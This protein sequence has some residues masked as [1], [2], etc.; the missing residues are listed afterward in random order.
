MVSVSTPADR[1]AAHRDLGAA[2]YSSNEV[3]LK[4]R[5]DNA[6]IGDVTSWAWPCLWS[7]G[8]HA[9]VCGWAVQAA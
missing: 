2:S 3:D 1:E 6:S 5:D 7:R 8:S 4:V 9:E